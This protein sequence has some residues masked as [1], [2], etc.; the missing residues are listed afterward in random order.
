MN[1]YVAFALLI[2]AGLDGIEADLPLPE[3]ADINLFTASE[4]TLSSFRHLPRS[5]TEANAAARESEFV[6]RHL[7]QAL[8]AAYC[9]R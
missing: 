6:R 8:I 9:D 7:P 2:H 1:P 5:L 3:S 4:E